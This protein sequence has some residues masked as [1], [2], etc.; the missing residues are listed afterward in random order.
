MEALT[1]QK[2]RIHRAQ[3]EAELDVRVESALPSRLAVGRG[4]AFV[5]W[6]CCFHRRQRIRELRVG[7]GGLETP[8]VA[9]AMPRPDLFAELH[10]TLSLPLA[11]PI[12][13][14]DDS[15]EDPFLMSYRSGFWAIARFEPIDEPT[16]VDLVVAARL[17]DGAVA[18][19][20]VGRIELDPGAV[21][22]GRRD[23]ERRRSRGPWSPS[24]WPPTSRRWTSSSDRCESIRSQTHANW[25]CVVSDDRSSPARFAEMQ[26]I[27]DGDPRFVVSRSPRHL[28]Y[29]HN[30]E[31]A[32]SMSAAERR[33]RDARRPGR[34]LAPRQAR[35][36]PGRP[37]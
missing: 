5:V 11:G 35:D 19:G 23:A 18:R 20:S 16:S 17:E 12:E 6:G 25:I 33:V 14:D 10:P 31:R 2:R 29:Y 21:R 1:S 13:R 26:R 24:A 4:N 27:L 15:A 37:R 34:Q 7:V 36:A 28:G 8:V 30:F 9:H 3:N 22:G 32:L